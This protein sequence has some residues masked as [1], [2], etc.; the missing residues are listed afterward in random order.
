MGRAVDFQ[1]SAL[2]DVIAVVY[3]EGLFNTILKD[4]MTLHRTSEVGGVRSFGE[5]S[6]NRLAP[7]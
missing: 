2:H 5:R 1:G 4:V 3:R 6:G 7:L